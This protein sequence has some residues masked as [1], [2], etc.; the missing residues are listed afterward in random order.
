MASDETETEGSERSIGAVFRHGAVY[1]LVPVLSNALSIAM[2]AFFT[3]WLHPDEMGVSQIVDLLLA[4]TIELVG[5]SAL[6]GMM[7]FYFDHKA[8]RDR[9]AVVSSTIVLGAVVSWAVCGGALLFG[10][11]LRP[12]L[13][14]APTGVVS[15]EYLDRVLLLALLVIPF[16]MTTQAGLRYLMIHQRSG[17]F[18]GIQVGKMVLEL[19]LKVWLVAPFG[20]ALGVKGVLLSVLVGEVVTSLGLS[21][22]VLRR[23]GLRV[24]WAVF[25]PVLTY[26]VPLTLASLCHLALQRSDLRLL[27]LLLPEGAGYTAAGI[28]GIGYRIGY[29][30]VP[31][32]LGPFMQIFLPWIYS[33][34]DRD[35]QAQL[36]ARLT[37]HALLLIGAAT[38]GLAVYAREAILLI[39]FSEGHQY[40]SAYQVVPLIGGA[41]LF[42]TVYR[43]MGETWFLIVK[44]TQALL[45]YS[46][47]ALAV[48]VGLN[49]VLIPMYGAVGAA[50]STLAAYMLLA[51]LGE[52]ARSRMSPVPLE[53]GRVLACLGVVAA[54]TGLALWSDHTFTEAGRFSVESLAAKTAVLVVA[55][56]VLWRA[57]LTAEERAALVAWGRRRLGRG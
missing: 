33:H 47:I 51:L 38:L 29:M 26:S 17:A 4:L 31:I 22:W 16:Q 15:A 10:D 49:F 23:V 39:D 35:E 42:W 14:G 40:E 19:G 53:Y 21:S 44:R 3:D 20:M 9:N 57:V 18:A 32:M 12:V 24:D 27:E 43:A 2:V 45:L 46:A 1:S 8:Q 41:Y 7:R 5:V 55:L 37:T 25:K 11:A 6:Q 56:G 28:Y 48:N 36:T 54:T 30:V 34:S 13:I 52:L 50:L